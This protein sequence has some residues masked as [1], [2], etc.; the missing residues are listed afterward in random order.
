MI[1]RIKSPMTF[2]LMGAMLIGA[3]IGSQIAPSAHAQFGAP[4]NNY[5]Q[6]WPTQWWDN[7]AYVHLQAPNFTDQVD[8]AIDDYLQTQFLP[9]ASTM[10]SCRALSDGHKWLDHRKIIYVVQNEWTSDVAP[11]GRVTA[12]RFNDHL[13]G[14][15]CPNVII[16]CKNTLANTESRLYVTGV[17]NRSSYKVEGGEVWLNTGKGTES[18]ERKQSTT[19]HELSHLVG[20]GH[21]GDL[22]LGPLDCLATQ[23]SIMWQPYCMEAWEQNDNP[24]IDELTPADIA[25]VN[26][27]H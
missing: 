17:C 5:G 4:N 15:Y 7:W 9:I 13:Y 23:P 12:Y 27:Y 3:A 8:G 2:V 14:V 10:R 11:L 25:A 20:L 1:C 18:A 22:A 19:T 26:G 21:I 24:I 16:H 6:Y